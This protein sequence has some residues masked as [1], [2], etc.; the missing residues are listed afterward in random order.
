[1]PFAVD[2]KTK[3]EAHA[4]KEEQRAHRTWVSNPGP[5][6][7]KRQCALQVC[8]S[9]ERPPVRIA[10]IFR[11]KGKRI[12]ENEK[13]AYH[14]D[15]DVYWQKNAWADTEFSIKWME[16]T[17]KPAVKDNENS[18][19]LLFC[20]NLSAQA[21]ALFLSKVR[22]LNG[23]VWFG[24]LGAMDIW[25]PVD[26]W[27]GNMLKSMVSKVQEEWLEDENNIDLPS[28]TD[29]KLNA[30]QRRIL[31]THWVGE[32]YN[33]SSGEQY[34]GSRLCCFEK[35]GWLTTADCSEDRK[36]NPE[37]LHGYSIPPPVPMNST[38]EPIQCQPPVPRPAPGDSEQPEESL[39][40]K[41]GLKRKESTKKVIGFS[42]TSKG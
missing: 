42:R 25:H 38:E 34:A 3:Y 13:M 21:D 18:E 23:I 17:L 36:R 41:T 22:A 39:Q 4:S 16:Q 19:F 20:D 30:K 29:Q 15:V 24:V 31:I 8:F 40:S 26:C 10:I 6:L 14:Q 33:R 28:N 37:G 1:M 5:G 32:A 2:W 12:S 9:P 35:T 7:E 11:G 27:F